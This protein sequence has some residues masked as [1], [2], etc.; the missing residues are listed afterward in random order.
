MEEGAER[1]GLRESPR[2]GG[3]EEVGYGLSCRT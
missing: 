1:E 3:K 2:G